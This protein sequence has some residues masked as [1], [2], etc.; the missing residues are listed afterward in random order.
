M[1]ADEFLAPHAV[2]RWATERPDAI[3][4]ERIEGGSR[5]YAEM[6]ATSQ[7]WASAFAG[8]GVC[9]GAHVATMLSNGFDALDAWLGLGWLRAVEVPDGMV[10]GNDFLTLFG[11]PKRQSACECER[12]SGG[13]LAQVLLLCALQPRRHRLESLQSLAS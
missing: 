9:A 10:G 1:L 4:V 6:L 12:S 7:R 11:R 2:A 5:T 8:H 13:T 3:A